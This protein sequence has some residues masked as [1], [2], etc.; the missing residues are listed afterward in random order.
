M[1]WLLSLFACK[2]APVDGEPGSTGCE[3]YPAG[4]DCSIW[5]CWTVYNNGQVGYRYKW[6]W[7]DDHFLHET[8]ECLG[9]YNC[10]DEAAL[11]ARNACPSGS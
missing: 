5:Q 4:Q 6:G 3:P 11:A 10:A 8:D 1:L 7:Q 2:P 9:V